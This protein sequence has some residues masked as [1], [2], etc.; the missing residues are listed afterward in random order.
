[1]TK[2]PASEWYAP[3]R[4]IKSLG[5]QAKRP[6]SLAGL[7]EARRGHL[8]QFFTPDDLVRFVWR[9]VNPAL[10]EAV[11]N[12]GRVSIYDS[13]VGSGRLFQ[14][15]SPDKHRLVG[16]DVHAPSI[17]R[18]MDTAEAAGFRTELVAAGLE[19]VAIKD[20]GLA[21]LNP[22]FSIHL[23]SPSL[24]PLACTS[25]GR[26]GPGT[27]AMSHEYAVEQALEGCAA[28]VAIVPR[29]QAD[30]LLNPDHIEHD[31]L[32]AVFHCPRSAFQ[33]EGADVS[34]SVVVYGRSSDTPPHVQVLQSLDDA[35]P[36]IPLAIHVKE[37]RLSV[38]GESRTEPVI[39]TPVTGN[40]RVRLVKNQ[41]YINLR[42][43]CG[44][45]EAKVRNALM[46]DFVKTGDK[47]RLPRGIRYRGEGRLD[48]EILLAQPNPVA[49]L[50]QVAQIVRDAGGAPVIDPTLEN[51]I[52]R[53]ARAVERGR[54]PF[55]HVV[56]LSGAERQSAGTV[57]AI[58]LKMRPL[59]IGEWGCP[60]LHP[61]T[62][63]EAEIVHTDEGRRYRM[64]FGGKEYLFTV[65]QMAERFRVESDEESG[66]TVLF[67][68]K[69]HAY[70]DIAASLYAQARQKGI[71][72]WLSWDY[73]LDD[74]VEL[75]IAPTGSA[76]AWEMG[77][78]KTRLAVGIVD[79][80]N[81]KHGLIVT[82]AGLIE[83]FVGE[84]E[85]LPY[86]R[87]EWQV[88]TSPEQCRDLRRFNIISYERLRLKAEGRKS[89][90]ALLRRRCSAVV[91]DEGDRVRNQSSQQTR[92]LWQLSAKRRFA[93]MGEPIANYP[94]DLLPILAWAVGDGTAIQPFGYERPY[95]E[96][97]LFD[98]MSYCQRGVDRF[99]DR[100]VSTVWITHEFKEN[101]D[102]SA[103]ARREIPRIADLDGYRAFHAP[104]MLRRTV[105]EPEVAKFLKI[106][107]P[108]LNDPHVIDWD[109][110]HLS[111]VLRVCDDFSRWFIGQME[112]ASKQGK[113]VNMV[114]LLAR[115]GAVE[116]AVDVPSCGLNGFGSYMPMTSKQRFTLDRVTELAEAGHKTILYVQNPALLEM[117]ERGFDERGIEMVPFHGGISPTRRMRDLNR[118][119]RKGS[120]P[121]LGATLGVT[122]RGLNIPQA[123]RVFFYSRSWSWTIESQAMRRVL[124]PQQKRPVG[125]EY[126]HLIGSIDDYKAQ[127]V[128]FKRDCRDAGVDYADPLM[129]HEEF[130]HLDTILHDFV[131]SVAEL[132]GMESHEYRDY[133]K[134]MAA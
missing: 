28:V 111:F 36:A 14:F 80:L 23:Q 108:T 2:N 48:T 115:I 65:E 20:C 70:P 6:G 37:A 99:A 87:D 66:W 38:T 62:P 46:E 25:H 79:L 110:A 132:H 51:F 15:A 121:V 17:T 90:A 3:L 19:E 133:L 75:A 86:S 21:L 71:H 35:I 104:M 9:I 39:T 131:K 84:M 107:V 26:Y 126:G 117:F 120:A 32:K 56:Q 103:G 123:D 74:L 5:S 16:C 4:E 118:R 129:Q 59:V 50:H 68:G 30:R 89:Y 11:R 33:E 114:A 83:E 60:I 96:E 119:F 22:P 95:I 116:R 10:D 122:Q 44:L 42:F 40:Q 105:Y 45:V 134:A 57:K 91:A 102:S 127:M 130:K 88:I 29:S 109:P 52:R 93:L 13:S 76:I 101:L 64:E 73:Q 124:R 112:Q 55:R 72:E 31:R 77:M 12:G 81:V 18:L 69:R 82:E 43:S 7:H 92:A 128:A 58:P 67:E 63:V 8:S 113:N 85:D 34:V 53:R 61:D 100:F 41:R 125:I 24:R 97:R 49:A 98:S 106:P 1:M 78:G 47:M 94:R 27:A 54:T